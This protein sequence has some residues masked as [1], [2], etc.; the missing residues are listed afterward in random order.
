MVF[1]CALVP[2]IQLFLQNHNNQVASKQFSFLPV[3]T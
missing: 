2:S 1:L 3:R